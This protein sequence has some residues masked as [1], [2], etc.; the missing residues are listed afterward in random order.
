MPDHRRSTSAASDFIKNH[1]QGRGC[2]PLDLA[3]KVADTFAVPCNIDNDVNVAALGAR[4]LIDPEL[5]ELAYL[6]VGTGVAAG[7]ILDGRIRRGHAGVAGEIGHFPIDHDGPLCRCG[8]RG[9][10][11]VMAS[12]RAIGRLWPTPTGRSPARELTEAAAVG[13]PDAVSVRQH[14]GRHL[15]TAVYLLTVTYDVGRIVIGG[16]VAELG[17]QL[18]SVIADGIDDLARRSEL[19]RSLALGE[20]ISLKPD[21]PVAAVGGAVLASGGERP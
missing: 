20:R 9:C 4:Q 8:L 2:P 21:G 18:L 19:V 15:A 10:L 12:G 6:S 3:D 14:L 7:I 11:E 1:E 17:E 16:G 13:H 5:P